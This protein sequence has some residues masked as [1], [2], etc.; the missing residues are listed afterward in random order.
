[1][2]A[3]VTTFDEGDSVMAQAKQQPIPSG[4][5]TFVDLMREAATAALQTAIQAGQATEALVER[6]VDGGLASH[7]ASVKAVRE[8]T[9]TL[10]Q[11]HKEWVAATAGVAA[12]ALSTGVAWRGASG[13]P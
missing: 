9:G 8:Y 10:F 12:R 13:P 1:M 3:A 7:E 4:P 11:T 6:A 2:L 5:A